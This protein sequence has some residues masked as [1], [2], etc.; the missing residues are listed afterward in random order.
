MPTYVTSNEMSVQRDVATC[1]EM[2]PTYQS[3]CRDMSFDMSRFCL[4]CH[5]SMD[6]LV[7]H[8]LLSV[9][10]RVTFNSPFVI[11]LISSDSSRTNIQH[12][13]VFITVKKLTPSSLCP[14]SYM[15]SSHSDPHASASTRITSTPSSCG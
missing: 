8:D 11:Q 2:S 9:S 13:R 1:H 5:V 6:M 15:S 12:I 3:T 4:T 7:P 10:K 14:Q